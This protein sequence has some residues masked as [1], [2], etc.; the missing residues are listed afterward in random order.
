MPALHIHFQI[1]VSRHRLHWVINGL[2]VVANVHV[3]CTSEAAVGD[4][5]IL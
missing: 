4:S 5:P 2:F 1:A 3:R